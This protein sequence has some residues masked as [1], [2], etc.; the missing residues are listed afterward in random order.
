[1]EIRERESESSLKILPS[2]TNKYNSECLFTTKIHLLIN[3]AI[4]VEIC[5]CY[6]KMSHTM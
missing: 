6:F 4:F 2:I 5:V 1:M 3:M